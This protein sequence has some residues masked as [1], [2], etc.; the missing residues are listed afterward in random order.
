MHR[1]RAKVKRTSTKTLR[2]DRHATRRPAA[3][4]PQGTA[5]RPGDAFE[6]RV[7]GY[8]IDVVRPTGSSSRSRPA[9]SP[10]CGRSSTRCSI[11]T[12]SGSCTRSRRGGGSCASTRTARCSP[13]ATPRGSPARRR[14]SRASSPSPPCSPTP[15]DDRDPALPRGPRPRAR[16]DARPALHARP[17]RTPADRGARTD[18]AAGA[19][20][21]AA[22]IPPLR[23]PVHHAR[24]RR[25][26]ARPAPARPEGGGLPTR[27]GGP[28][29]RRGCADER[30]S[31]VRAVQRRLRQTGV[32]EA[33]E[34]RRLRSVGSRHP[35]APVRG[36]D[37]ERRAELL[38]VVEG[39]LRDAAL[40][41]GERARVGGE[42]EDAGAE[43]VRPG[44]RP[45]RRRRR[46]PVG[47]GVFGRADDDAARS[48]RPPVALAACSGRS[49]RST[50]TR[51]AG[52]GARPGP[53]GSSRPSRRACA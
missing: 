14:S 2:R 38:V 11:A 53:R 16:P 9:V 22:L 12:G 35:H 52:R 47:V 30:L 32:L 31:T 5:R 7:D 25:G 3:P 23:R 36:G 18:R 26:D 8:V 1:A 45:A 29:A 44:G 34:R 39:D 42:R 13:R 6:V 4:R 37:A 10:R 49:E 33:S 27:A 41:A 19:A 51:G 20:D 17:G 43:P 50:T 46:E 24:A 40:V 28:R 48:S 15:P 21:V